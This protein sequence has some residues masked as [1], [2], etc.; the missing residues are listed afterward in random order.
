MVATVVWLLLQHFLALLEP[1]VALHE[2]LDPPVLRRLEL[3][4]ASSY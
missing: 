2:L 1:P 4:A 3:F